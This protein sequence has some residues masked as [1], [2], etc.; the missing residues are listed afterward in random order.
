MN[1]SLLSVVIPCK[2]E[3]KYLFSILNG[4]ENQ[5]FDMQNV[6]VYIADADSTDESPN[7]I[8]KFRK[9]SKMDIQIVEGGYPPKGR[10]NGASHCK[11]KYILF[12]DADIEPGEQST[13]Q[14]S[15]E[16]AEANDLDLVSTF[17]KCKDG[18][19]YDKVF[20]EKVHGFTYRYP[21]ILGPFA[22]GMFILIKREK[23]HELGG[24]NEKMVLGDDWELTHKIQ[25]DK[26]G[27]ADTY[28]WTTN[29]RFKKSG[30]IKTVGQYLMIAM[31][32]EYR[33]KGH[34][35]YMH[36]EY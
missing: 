5:S 35:S 26:F 8:N 36:V 33:N 32:K 6:P 16:L 11:S 15:I 28:I 18:N 14:K 23:F 21:Q 13:I 9:H 20:W 31:S 12:M 22:A 2:N 25:R 3:E 1:E 4:L 29:R 30:Y 27:V 24:F 19:I 17:I 7:I 10:N 34:R